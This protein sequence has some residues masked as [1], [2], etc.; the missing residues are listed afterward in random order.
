MEPIAILSVI[1]SA[2]AIPMSSL[3]QRLRTPGHGPDV[4]AN[5]ASTSP[6]PATSGGTPKAESDLAIRHRQAQ[7]E[8]EGHELKNTLAQLEREQ[9]IV[10]RNVGEEAIYSI[11]AK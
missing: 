10:A 9:L 2:L 4:G 1:S 5:A 3:L 8:E 7:A 6:R 11:T